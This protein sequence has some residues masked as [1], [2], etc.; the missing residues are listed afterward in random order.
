MASQADKLGLNLTL[1]DNRF[2][3]QTKLKK[4]KEP[5]ERGQ[6]AGQLDFIFSCISYAVGLG[7]VWRFP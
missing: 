6:W 3:G 2:D 1:N 7:N 5:V 4:E